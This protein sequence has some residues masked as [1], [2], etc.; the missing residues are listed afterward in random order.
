MKGA[1]VFLLT[2]W[3]SVWL[4]G[5]IAMVM[6]GI[7][8]ND[9]SRIA[10]GALSLALSSITVFGGW[11]TITSWYGRVLTL[12]YGGGAC[13]IGW[14]VTFLMLGSL[15]LSLGVQYEMSQDELVVQIF[16]NNKP[17]EMMTL[18]V[19]WALIFI[20]GFIYMKKNL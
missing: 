11:G 17:V 10:G 2:N 9:T 4:G 7:L 14:G 15:M 1:W 12:G 19:G 16:G 13:A 6:H 8:S 3:K 18:V 20:G 5:S